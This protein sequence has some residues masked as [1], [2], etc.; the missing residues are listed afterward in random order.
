MSTTKENRNA[1]EEPKLPECDDCGYSPTRAS[2]DLA[3]R[4]AEAGYERPYVEVEFG[5]AA[6]G[7][8]LLCPVCGALVRRTD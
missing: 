2:D 4:L 6:E 5:P 8:A 1:V 7:R 3:R